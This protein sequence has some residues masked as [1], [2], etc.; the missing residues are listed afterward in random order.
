LSFSFSSLTTAASSSM[1][2][3]N[4]TYNVLI[5]AIKI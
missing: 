1:I 3:E 2:P 4:M 5:M